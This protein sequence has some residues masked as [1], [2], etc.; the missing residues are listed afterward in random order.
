MSSLSS[1]YIHTYSFNMLRVALWP[2]NW[3]IFENVSSIFKKNIYSHWWNVHEINLVK[4][5]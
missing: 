4:C 5:I 3:P 2:D 1:K